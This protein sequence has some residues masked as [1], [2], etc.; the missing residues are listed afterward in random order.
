[1]SHYVAKSPFE[2]SLFDER[3]QNRHMGEEDIHMTAAVVGNDL[4]SVNIFLQDQYGCYGWGG[5]ANE[6]G[7]DVC[8]YDLLEWHAVTRAIRGGLRF[9]DTGG[10][11]VWVRKLRARQS[12]RYSNSLS[13]YPSLLVL[14]RGAGRLYRWY[15]GW[16]KRRFRARSG[17]SSP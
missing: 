4:V 1:M 9:L 16:L 12:I 15:R 13:K 17:V 5:A 8:A 6:K 14:R 11:N 7:R 10:N 3:A 2:N